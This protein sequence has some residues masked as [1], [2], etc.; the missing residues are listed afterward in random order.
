MIHNL[1]TSDYGRTIGTE[2]RGP[3][4]AKYAESFGAKGIRVEDDSELKSSLARALMADGPVIVDVLCG[5]E[6]PHPAPAE[7]LQGRQ[8]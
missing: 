1:Q 8:V 2:L 6:F 3:D 4:F 7:W 5:Y